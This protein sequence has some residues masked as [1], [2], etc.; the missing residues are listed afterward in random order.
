MFDYLSLTPKGNLGGIEIQ[1][2]LEENSTDTL[3]TTEHPVESGAFITDHS[4]KKPIEV[5]IKCGWSNSSAKAV[6]GGAGVSDIQ[7][8]YIS[9]S[10]YVSGVYSQLIA[11]QEARVPFAI[12]TSRRL[13]ENMLL[14]GIQRTT[15]EK[16]SAVLMVTATCREVITVTTQATTVPTADKQE[17]PESTASTTNSGVVSPISAVPSP[18][19]SAPPVVSSAVNAAQAASNTGGW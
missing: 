5:V 3:Q 2:T 9:G 8:G 16:T 7:N 10:D 11:L 15:D 19:G 6:T 14:V 17:T 1:A 4:Y 12:E 18:G 13:Y